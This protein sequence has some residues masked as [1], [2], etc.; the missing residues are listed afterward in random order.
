MENTECKLF[1]YTIYNK[2][3]ECFV[4]KKNPFIDDE[5]YGYE[6]DQIFSYDDELV[7]DIGKILIGKKL[8]EKY[9]MLDY[10]LIDLYIKMLAYTINKENFEEIVYNKYKN[11]KKIENDK[12]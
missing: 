12:P 2:I 8:E 10:S 11:I 4:C 6:E 1:I 5:S 7:G 9:E 3:E